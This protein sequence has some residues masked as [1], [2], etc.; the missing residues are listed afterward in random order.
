MDRG[1]KYVLRDKQ[2]RRDD[3]CNVAEADGSTVKA[4]ARTTQ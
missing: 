1:R 2:Q 4:A 3:V